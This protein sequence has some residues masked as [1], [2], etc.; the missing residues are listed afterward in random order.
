M[1]PLVKFYDGV[2][3]RDAPILLRVPH[4]AVTPLRF[5]ISS[6]TYLPTIVCDKLCFMVLYNKFAS[7]LYIKFL[8]SCS[9]RVFGFRV[10]RYRIRDYSL[11]HTRTS[12]IFRYTGRNSSRPCGHYPFGCDRMW[13]HVNEPAHQFTSTNP[14]QVF[15]TLSLTFVE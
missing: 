9:I 15:V 11:M 1:R 8:V 2:I 6:L 12:T 7:I 4:V 13:N 14:L 3:V 10:V 5:I